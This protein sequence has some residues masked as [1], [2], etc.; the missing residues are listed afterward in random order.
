MKSVTSLAKVERTS[1]DDILQYS[2]LLVNNALK[3][4]DAN[5]GCT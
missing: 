5:P 2:N 4:K 3:A 1:F